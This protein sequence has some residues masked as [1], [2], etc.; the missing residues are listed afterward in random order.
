[1]IKKVIK[2]VG[3]GLSLLFVLPILLPCSLQA[4]SANR[5]LQQQLN[6]MHSL[7]ANFTQ[8]IYD[9]NS[10]PLDRSQGKLVIERPNRFLWQVVQP[11]AQTIV[12]N[13]DK[14]WIYDPDLKQVT[15]SKLGNRISQTP[16][17]LLSSD[18]INLADDF[19]VSQQPDGS[20]LLIP[21]QSDQSFE[22]VQLWFNNNMIKRM[23]LKTD[24]GQVSRIDFSDVKQNISL[25]SQLFSPTFAK[26]ITV[27]NQY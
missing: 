3:M 26:D 27:V 15:V 7:S 13:G 9:Q 4:Q 18:K 1:M 21:K 22:S 11:L 12:T 2:K 14:L 24:V 5:A 17:L 19:T 6:T 16:M 23:V 20:Y 10:K 25:N 8:R